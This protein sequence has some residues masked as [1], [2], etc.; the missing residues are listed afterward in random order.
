MNQ[1]KDEVVID[2][3]DLFRY[4]VSKW[5]II[6]LG[7]VI[8]GGAA[9]GYT[10]IKQEPIYT[11]KIKLY[12]TMPK[13]SDKVIIRDNASELVNDYIE[14]TTTDLVIGKIA[15]TSKIPENEVKGAISAAA[16]E[17]TR[18]FEITVKT[19]NESKTKKIAKVTEKELMD[20]ITV[21]LKKDAPVLVEMTKNPE[22]SES[23]SI[24]KNTVVGAAGG[25]V[26]VA[27]ILFVVY[28][29]RILK[30]NIVA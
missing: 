1:Q 24:K 25:F 18:I 6:I 26:L 12:V 22:F 9:F 8:C 19:G 23:M 17:N 13:T 15:K 10:K 16:V 3:V 21:D 27:G 29:I 7:M 2:L 30:K 20:T 28:M 11:S 4:I 14:L 5:L